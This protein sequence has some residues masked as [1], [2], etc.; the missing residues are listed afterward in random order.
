MKKFTSK[1][2]FLDSETIAEQLRLARQAKKLKLK[3]IATKL[4]I[5][6]HYLRA[7][8]KGEY[9]KLP[10]GIYGK[11]FLKRYA[12]FLG[13]DHRQLLQLFNSEFQST[14]RVKQRQ[15][16]A[17]Q[18]VTARYFLALPNLLRGL[19]IIIITVICFAYLGYRLEKII[20]PPYLNISQPPDNLITREQS[21]E[22]IGQTET[23]AQIIINGETVL[24][25]HNGNFTKTI[26][27]KD[28]LNIISITA[29]KKY[30]RDKN[31]VKQILLTDEDE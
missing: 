14:R 3:E 26:Y 23:E 22:I 2:I 4:N 10:Q 19:T 9:H 27:L 6:Y 15:L 17:K 12:I 7:L 13:L 31:I 28:G 21:L 30:G 25:D 24:S 8:E 29:T 16:F 5:N 20:S 1:K 18:R 11:N